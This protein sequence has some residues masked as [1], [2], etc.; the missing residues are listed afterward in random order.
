MTTPYFNRTAGA[1]ARALNAIKTAHCAPP[2][3]KPTEPVAGSNPCTMKGCKGIIKFTVRP[4]DGG[5]SG[6]C[7][8]RGCL[9]WRE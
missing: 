3:Y 2:A 9:D 8:T 5:T 4:S 6:T 7:T 1:I